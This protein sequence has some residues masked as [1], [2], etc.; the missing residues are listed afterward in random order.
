MLDQVAIAFDS[1]DYHTVAK[2]L[3]QLYT[4]A[5]SLDALSSDESRVAISL[6]LIPYS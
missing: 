5:K 1:K 6:L 2:L 4:V 3:K